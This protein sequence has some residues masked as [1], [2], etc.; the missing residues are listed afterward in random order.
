M[1]Y[2]YGT[3]NAPAVGNGLGGLPRRAV[4]AAAAPTTAAEFKAII[5]SNSVQANLIEP[6]T[7][8]VFVSF[9]SVQ[10]KINYNGVIVW[11]KE[12]SAG[13]S[14][15][16]EDGSSIYALMSDYYIRLY[17][18][19]MQTYSAS[20]R[21]HSTTLVQDIAVG[22]DAIYAVG[23][24]TGGTV[25]NIHKINKSLTANIWTRQISSAGNSVIQCV[26]ATSDGGCLVGGYVGHDTPNSLFG[27]AVF[28][29]IDA[30]GTQQWSKTFAGGSNRYGKISSLTED[31]NFYHG[32][33]S[34]DTGGGY[35]RLIQ[36]T[37]DGATSWGCTIGD[38]DTWEYSSH[39]NRSIAVNGDLLFC[40]NGYSSGI[41][42]YR[43]NA[44]ILT[45]NPSLASPQRF[46]KRSIFQIDCLFPHSTGRFPFDG[47]TRYRRG[48]ATIGRVSKQYSSSYSD[49]CVLLLADFSSLSQFKVNMNDSEA[50]SSPTASTVVSKSVLFDTAAVFTATPITT[51]H[52]FSSIALTATVGSTGS[53]TTSTTYSVQEV[54]TQ[55]G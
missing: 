31:D 18:S 7:D 40:I 5:F 22:A 28:I 35:D 37:K 45:K 39:K 50:V 9:G 21:P 33:N 26:T 54:L 20:I 10:T 53:S 4:A 2:P 11:Q 44:A 41:N 43:G 30:D 8:A 29:K 25:S 12:T 17:D 48:F 13:V 19:D 47:V 16:I 32:L 1:P 51:V 49:K 55:Q 46:A 38:S 23:Q 6:L 24:N 3:Q 14:R 52:T 34:Y 27:E 42:Q 36:L 15:A